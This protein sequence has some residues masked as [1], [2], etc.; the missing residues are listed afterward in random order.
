MSDELTTEER[1]L[2]CHALGLQLGCDRRTAYRNRFICDAKD[3]VWSSLK[4]RGLATSQDVA[5]LGDGDI[6]FLVTD[7]GC[8]ALLGMTWRKAEDRRFT[9]NEVRGAHGLPPAPKLTRSQKRY[10]RYLEYGDR[11]SSFIEFCKWDSEKGRSW[12]A[13]G[14][15]TA[16][17]ECRRE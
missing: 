8:I 14:S 10:Q 9:E 2:M 3:P 12:N 5:F 16:R 11:F 1:E 4:E 15:T 7:A 6:C 13:L 17:S